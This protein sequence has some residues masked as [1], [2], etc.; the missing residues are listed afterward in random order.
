ME[1]ELSGIFLSKS[2]HQ[3]YSVWF[4]SDPTPSFGSVM[5]LFEETYKS[6]EPNCY[7]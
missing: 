7:T 4:P 6:S 1:F 2:G 5:S 3:K